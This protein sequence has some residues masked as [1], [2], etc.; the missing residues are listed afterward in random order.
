MTI[1]FALLAALV[2]HAFAEF[3]FFLLHATGVL[4]EKNFEPFLV[5]YFTLPLVCVGVAL[6]A[7]RTRFRLTYGILEVIISIGIMMLAVD[8][9]A[10]ALQSESANALRKPVVGSLRW[11]PTSIAWLQIAAAVYIFVRGMDNIGEGLR[12]FPDHPI[13]QKWKALFPR[14]ADLK[15]TWLQYLRRAA[16]PG[17]VWDEDGNLTP[18]P[19]VRVDA[20]TK[21]DKDEPLSTHKKE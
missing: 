7:L 4:T 16:R 8:S 19:L 17:P 10:A 5:H 18:T 20:D 13:A 11:F 6:Y 1:F 21:P 14:K 15:Y 2:L 9:F 12:D 3:V